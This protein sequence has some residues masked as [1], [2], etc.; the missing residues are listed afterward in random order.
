MEVQVLNSMLVKILLN[1]FG[2]LVFLFLFWRRL[3]EDYSAN[4]IFSTALYM[5]LGVGAASYLSWRLFPSWWFW[6]S[7]FGTSLG[8]TFGILR[9]RLRIFET[10]EASVISLLPWLGLTFL[11]DSLTN[12]NLTSSVGAA[13][14]LGLIV[15]FFL[16]DKHYKS[17]S[18]YKS[19]R[20]G[21]S[22]LTILGLFFLSRAAIAASI[23]NVLSFS[24]KYEVFLSAVLAFVSFLL[25]FNLSRSEI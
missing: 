6:A 23:T 13:A 18:W 3:R 12:T 20:V 9:Y 21:F 14:I 19:G 10:V 15:A 24:G 2:I 7:F 1:A 16:L 11:I 22:G 25:V 4:A 5:L 8:L 17:F